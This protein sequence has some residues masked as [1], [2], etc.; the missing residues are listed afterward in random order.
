MTIVANTASIATINIS[1]LQS[2]DP[3]I[4]VLEAFSFEALCF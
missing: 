1:A 3:L 2:G 4:H